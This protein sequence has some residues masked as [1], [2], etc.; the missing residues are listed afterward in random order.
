[1]AITKV[2]DWTWFSDQIGGE[3][4]KTKKAALA[5]EAELNATIYA[6]IVALPC[7][8]RWSQP[9]CANTAKSP[10]WHLCQACTDARKA[11]RS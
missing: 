7:R 11:A 3:K 4:F 9:D 6:P 8:G 2:N 10:S 5:A 1:M